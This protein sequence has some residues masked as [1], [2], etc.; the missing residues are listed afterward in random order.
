MLAIS[1]VFRTSSQTSRNPNNINYT[2]RYVNYLVASFLDGKEKQRKKKSSSLSKK[3]RTD[4]TRGK[5]HPLPSFS[6][7][8]TRSAVDRHTPHA[9]H[10]RHDERANNTRLRLPPSRVWVQPRTSKAGKKGTTKLLLRRAPVCDTHHVVVVTNKQAC[11]QKRET[12]RKMQRRL[13]T[14]SA[15]RRGW[16]W[17]SRLWRGRRITWCV[18]EKPPKPHCTLSSRACVSTSSAIERADTSRVFV[19]SGAHCTYKS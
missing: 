7:S 4:L 3:R 2:S 9:A 8:D 10:T 11:L 17:W 12:A 6:P 1:G 13:G 18:N 5:H 14:T 19:A 16:R 15:R